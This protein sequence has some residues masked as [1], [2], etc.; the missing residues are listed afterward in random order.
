MKK[1]LD[2][3]TLKWCA[4]QLRKASSEAFSMS[5]PRGAVNSTIWAS[6]NECAARG[7]MLLALSVSIK[8]G[9]KL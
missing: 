6:P 5:K 4:K 1:K 8:N 9:E 3:R 7:S 2:K